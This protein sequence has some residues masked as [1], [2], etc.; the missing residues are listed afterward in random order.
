MSHNLFAGVESFLHVDGYLM[1]RVV[2]AEGWG[3][4]GDFLK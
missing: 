4:S 2:V 3:G 1:I